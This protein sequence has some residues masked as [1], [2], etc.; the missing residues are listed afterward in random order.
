[1][2][3]LYVEFDKEDIEFADAL[4]SCFK[5]DC[6]IMEKKHLNGG[7]EV[8][9]AVITIIDVTLHCIEFFKTYLA[10]SNNRGRVFLTQEGRNNMK[11]CSENEIMNIL[12]GV[13]EIEDES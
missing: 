7:V 3:E 13:N 9:I 12:E 5:D 1:M 8:F 11:G 2:K 4:K 10:D 6:E